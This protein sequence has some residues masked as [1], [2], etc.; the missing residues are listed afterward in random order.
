MSD[1]VAAGGGRWITILGLFHARKCRLPEE[2]ALRSWMDTRAGPQTLETGSWS[3]IIPASLPPHSLPGRAALP[4][5]VPAC[6]PPTSSAVPSIPASPLNS[7]LLG[8]ASWVH[9][10]LSPPRVPPSPPPH[11]HIAAPRNRAKNLLDRAVR[12]KAILQVE[13]RALPKATQR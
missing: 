12:A 9:T 10:L 8:E 3:D 6:Q 5:A 1:F 2:W 13:G 4:Q 7:H 11:T